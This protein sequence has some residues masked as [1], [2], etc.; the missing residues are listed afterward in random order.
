MK[1]IVHEG[2]KSYRAHCS[3]CGA[4]FTYE[5]E[6]VHRDYVHGGERVSCPC[7][8]TGLRHFG[9]SGTRWPSASEEIWART[10]LD[11]GCT[12]RGPS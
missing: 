11:D 8:G 10:L 1:R 9:A 3:E 7:C 4:V 5:R 2:S 6:D 12:G